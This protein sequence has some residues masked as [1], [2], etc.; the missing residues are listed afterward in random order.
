VK[1]VL[2]V[3]EELD[4]A[5]PDGRDRAAEVLGDFLRGAMLDTAAARLVVGRLVSLAVTEPVVKVRDSALNAV[6]EAFDHYRL[7]LGLVEPLASAVRALEPELL[8]YALHIFGATQDPRAQ[9][10]IEP[11]LRHPDP[12]V[13]EEARLAYA[14]VAVPTN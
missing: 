11:F 10:L 3:L 8:A 6:S 7:P 14:E 1:D 13:R 12:N 9:S 4:D 5:D 2:A